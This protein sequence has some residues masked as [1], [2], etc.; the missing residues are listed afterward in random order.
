VI[1]NATGSN[2]TVTVTGAGS[3]WTNFALLY[4][5]GNSANPGGTG[6]LQISDGGSVSALGTTIWNT[7]TLTIGG[8]FTL[9]SPLTVN[10]GTI[11][12]ISNTT[13][14]NDATLGSG[15]VILDSEAFNS[16]FSGSFTGSGGITKTGSG[17]VTLSGKSNYSCGTT[18]NSGTLI[19][20]SSTAL[21]SGFVSVTGSSSTLQINNGIGLGTTPMLSNGGT[22][23]KFWK[24]CGRRYFIFWRRDRGQLRRGG[25]IEYPGLVSNR[26]HWNSLSENDRVGNRNFGWPNECFQRW[27]HQWERHFERRA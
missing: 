11:R 16:T 12:T 27:D 3:T 8:N 23:N 10:G 6:N 18:I 20:A 4:V 7:G 9:N 1:G 24:S 15:G 21:G 26:H 25:D 5:G 14:P 2:G 17:S 13:F 19:D 22:V